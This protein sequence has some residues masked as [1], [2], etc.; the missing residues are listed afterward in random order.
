[1]A[2]PS[3]E[4]LACV[5]RLPTDA[6]GMT[7]L[8]LRSHLDKTIQLIDRQSELSCDRAN[9]R[10]YLGHNLGTG[11]IDRRKVYDWQDSQQL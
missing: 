2:F 9:Q 3:P 10:Q 8:E 1:M 4:V 5:C 7:L 11:I 6:Y